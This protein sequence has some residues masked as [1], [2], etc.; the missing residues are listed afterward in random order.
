MQI[1]ITQVLQ[2]TAL[3]SLADHLKHGLYVHKC[4]I[5]F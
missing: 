4:N 1:L 3:I 2:V 5:C